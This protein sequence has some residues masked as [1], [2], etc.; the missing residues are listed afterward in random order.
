MAV[1]ST[2][3]AILHQIPEGHVGV[4]W[5]GGALLNTISEPGMFKSHCVF[6]ISGSAIYFGFLHYYRNMPAGIYVNFS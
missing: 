6:V 1:A 3:L 5:R 4:Y 2:N